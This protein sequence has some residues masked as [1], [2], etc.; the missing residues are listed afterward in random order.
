ME[1]EIAEQHFQNWFATCIQPR[2]H[3]LGF[4]KNAESVTFEVIFPD[5]TGVADIFYT[6]DDWYNCSSIVFP[7]GECNEHIPIQLE[8]ANILCVIYLYRL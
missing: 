5:T 1:E 6:Y 8:L 3:K 2:A 4:D 7:D